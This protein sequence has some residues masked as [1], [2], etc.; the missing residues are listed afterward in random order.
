MSLGDALGRNK[1]RLRSS[2]LLGGL[3][4]Q[5]TRED[6]LQKFLMALEKTQGDSASQ[7]GMPQ[8]S[9]FMGNVANQAGTPTGM[10]VGKMLGNMFSGGGGGYTGR[11][12]TPSRGGLGS[13]AVGNLPGIKGIAQGLLAK[14]GW[15]GAQ[16][17]AFDRLIQ[18]E[19]SWNPN[20][21][22]PTSSARGLGQKMTSIHGP[23][24][25][26][27]EGQLGWV[28]NYIAGRYGDPVKALQFHLAHNW[29]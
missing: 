21:A 25:D 2:D 26:S 9:Q 13:Q 20:A 4:A 7:R 14:R 3:G 23:L 6:P 8:M 27:V 24:E 28:M 29:Y 12:G 11:A 16:W 22:N 19:S 10:A 18:K 1:G 15:T 17:D 5:A